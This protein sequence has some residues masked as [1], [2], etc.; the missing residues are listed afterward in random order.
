MLLEK[1]RGRKGDRTFEGWEWRVSRKW[2]SRNFHK[3]TLYLAPHCKFLRWAK[4]T[5]KDMSDF[6]IAAGKWWSLDHSTRAV[7]SIN[8][9][10]LTHSYIVTCICACHFALLLY[11]PRSSHAR[12]KN[13]GIFCAGLLMR[14]PVIQVSFSKRKHSAKTSS[15]V[16]CFFVHSLFYACAKNVFNIAGKIFQQRISLFPHFEQ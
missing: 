5:L 12:A 13:R 3:R 1:T 9:R 11:I 15:F 2:H 8:A 16:Y 4:R 7:L 14:K 6:F 10:V